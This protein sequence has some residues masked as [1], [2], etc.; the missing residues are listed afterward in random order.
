MQRP[1]SSGRP[2]R[3]GYHAGMTAASVPQPPGPGG[4]RMSPRCP[5]HQGPQLPLF[6]PRP[7][8]RLAP[9]LRRAMLPALAELLA[10]AA[11]PPPA[12]APRGEPRA[13]A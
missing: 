10:A 6:A 8:I 12:T 7:R 5:R 3:R 4:D 9:A 11:G 13:D 2:P 1:R